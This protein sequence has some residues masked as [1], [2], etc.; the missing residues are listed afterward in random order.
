MIGALRYCAVPGVTQAVL[1]LAE[2][3]REPIEVGQ[4]PI[5]SRKVEKGVE[6]L[7]KE[8]AALNTWY[9]S[10]AGHFTLNQL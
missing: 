2:L 9:K 6:Q 10:H 7:E 4:A 8:Y 3:I 5:D 1:H